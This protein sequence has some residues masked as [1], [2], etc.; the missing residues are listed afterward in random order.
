MNANVKFGLILGVAVAAVGFLVAILGI[1]K[2]P[3]LSAVFAPVAIIINVV[4]VFLALRE[5]ADT[6]AWGGQVVNALI[7]GGVGA[8]LIFLGSWTMTALVF[9]NYYVEAAAGMADTLAA[10]GMTSEQIAAQ[11]AAAESASP[12]GSALSGAIG[13]LITS[14][15]GGAIIAIFKRKKAD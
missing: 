11:V 5:T 4:C 14:A 13:A 3:M 6:A 15:I 8:V 9:P 7:V 12:A 2:S 10:A 1:H